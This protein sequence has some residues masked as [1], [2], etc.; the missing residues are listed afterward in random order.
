M[1]FITCRVSDLSIV[2]RQILHELLISMNIKLVSICL[3]LTFFKY[4]ALY[5]IEKKRRKNQQNIVL[6]KQLHSKNL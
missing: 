6:I 1:I 4:K 5:N 3:Y 2:V